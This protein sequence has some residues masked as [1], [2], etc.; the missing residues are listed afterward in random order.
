M[1]HFG[2]NAQKLQE[3][4]NITGMGKEETS[5]LINAGSLKAEDAL[6]QQEWLD[7]M[8]AEDIAWWILYALL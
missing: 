8:D 3:V 6:L 4:V 5:F 1:V 7:E 2:I